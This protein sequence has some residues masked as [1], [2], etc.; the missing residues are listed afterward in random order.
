[1]STG[2]V[3]ETVKIPIAAGNLFLGSFY[4]NNAVQKRLKATRFGLP[5]GKIPLHV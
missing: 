1:K 2:Q 3:G 4:V 5:F